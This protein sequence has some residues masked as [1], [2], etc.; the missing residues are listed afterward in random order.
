VNDDFFEVGGESLIATQLATR[1]R[2]IYGV[3]L[4]LKSL[5]AE[6][7]IAGVCRLIEESMRTPTETGSGNEIL[8]V[9]RQSRKAKRSADGVFELQA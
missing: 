7:T 2:D 4:S 5:F 8:P 1:I 9:A 6:P 3:H